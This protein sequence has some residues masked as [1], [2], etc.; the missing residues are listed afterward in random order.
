MAQNKKK[1][2]KKKMVRN[3]NYNFL[4]FTQQLFSTTKQKKNMTKEDK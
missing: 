3:E 2:K 4:S 1:L